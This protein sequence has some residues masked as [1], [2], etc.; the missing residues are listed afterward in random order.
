MDKGFK[1]EDGQTPPCLPDSFRW[2]VYKR[3]KEL[4]EVLTGETFHPVC[5]IEF[6]DE[7]SHIFSKYK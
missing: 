2:S 4:Y 6:D 3:Y 7:L 5:T 1:G